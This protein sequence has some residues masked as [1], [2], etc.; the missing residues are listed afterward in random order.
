PP[1]EGRALLQGLVVCGRCGRRM[2]VRYKGRVDGPPVPEYVCQRDGINNAHP[3]CQYMHGHTIDAAVA[4]LALETLTPLALEVALAVSDELHPH[5]AQA[6][7][8]RAPHAQRAQPA[9]DAAR[10]RYLA[11]DPAN[12]L[13]ADTLEADWN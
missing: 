7:Q 13:V 8:L 12:R 4:D 3:V 6:D 11:V 5:A 9:A 10:R 1:R 2:T